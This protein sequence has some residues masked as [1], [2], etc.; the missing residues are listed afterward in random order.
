MIILVQGMHRSGTSALAGLLSTGGIFMGDV[1]L[2]KS[3][4]NPK[5]HFE[6]V[7]LLSLNRRIL[8]FFNGNWRKVPKGMKFEKL[9]SG[10]QKEMKDLCGKYIVDHKVWGWKEPRLGVTFPLWYEVMK[11]EKIVFLYVIRDP[12]EVWKSLQKR[13]RVFSEEEAR[14]LWSLYNKKIERSILDCKI[15]SLLIPFDGLMNA[16]DYHQ[17]RIEEFCGIDLGKGFTFIESKYRNWT[18]N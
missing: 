5:G 8:K 11:D 17:A 9:P 13:H 14:L 4:N 15:Q 1:L 16:P 10:L 2:R 7:K 3:R 6:D 12:R 18:S